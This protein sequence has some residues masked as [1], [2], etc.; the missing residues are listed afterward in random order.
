MGLL[1]PSLL[2]GGAAWHTPLG[3]VAFSPLFLEGAAF[4]HLL[5]MEL[6]SPFLFCS[7]VLLGLLQCWAVLGGSVLRDGSCVG[8]LGWALGR[9]FGGWFWGAWV[10]GCRFGC[11]TGSLGVGS[12]LPS[13]GGGLAF[14]L[15]SGFGPSFL[16]L[17]VGLCGRLGC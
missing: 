2:L 7:V 6:L 10:V 3:G 11:L 9:V 15:G 16:W 14:F 17:E 8:W 5:G 1:F 4:L 13:R 12:G